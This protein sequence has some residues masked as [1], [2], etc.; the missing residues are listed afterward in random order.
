MNRRKKTIF[1]CILICI[2][3]IIIL[4]FVIKILKKESRKNV[5]YQ[6]MGI[7]EEAI[8]EKILSFSNFK[9][10]NIFSEDKKKQSIIMQTIEKIFTNYIPN[11]FSITQNMSTEELQ[12]YYEQNENGITSRLYS[13]DEESFVKLM[14]QVNTMNSNLFNDYK[15]CRFEKNDSDSLKVIC[16]YDNGEEIKLILD[17]NYI[18]SY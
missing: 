6:I 3:L 5:E 4:T 17:R 18:L 12:L 10:L 1:R 7:P 13:I 14:E 8:P 15:D 9:E 2:F 16:L 11:Y